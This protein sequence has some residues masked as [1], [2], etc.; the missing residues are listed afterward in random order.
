MVIEEQPTKVIQSNGT[1][2]WYLASKGPSYFHREDGPALIYPDGTEYWFF[3]GRI[4]REGGPAIINLN[5]KRRHWF[6][7]GRRHRVD[8]PAIEYDN[9][10]RENFWCLETKE[11]SLPAKEVEAWIK[12]EQIDLSTVEGQMAFVLRWG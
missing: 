5:H 6:K 11:D 7:D 1:V 3:N 8:G 10:P 9:D 4:H 12:E 2:I